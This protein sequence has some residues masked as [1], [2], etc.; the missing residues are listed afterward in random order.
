MK[1]TKIEALKREI[2]LYELV[3]IALKKEIGEKG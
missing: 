3:E 2:K 1:K